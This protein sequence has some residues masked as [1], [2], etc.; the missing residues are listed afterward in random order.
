VGG[1]SPRGL[2]RLGGNP[3]QCLPAEL[4]RGFLVIKTA[5]CKLGG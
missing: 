5:P 3:R 2:C 4:A 1:V